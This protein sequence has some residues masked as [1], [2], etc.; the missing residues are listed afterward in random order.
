MEERKCE[1]K[2]EDL[3]EDYDKAK[4]KECNAFKYKLISF[5]NNKININLIQHHLH[6]DSDVSIFEKVLT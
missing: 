5:K 2:S 6:I 3:D 4:S 1:L